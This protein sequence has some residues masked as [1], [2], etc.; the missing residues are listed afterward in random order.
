MTEYYLDVEDVVSDF[1][2]VF[3]V[4]PKARSE[5]TDSNNLTAVNTQFEY[6]VTPS[7]GSV[8]CITS[9]TVN[10]TEQVKWQDYYWDYQNSKVFFLDED[11]FSGGEAIVIN[12]KYG[13]SNWIYSDKPDDELGKAAFPRISLFTIS[14][15]G[16]KIGGAD[17][18]I[19]SRPI[20]QIDCWTRVDEIS[21]IDSRK[22]SNEYLGRYLGNQVVNSFDDSEEKLFGVFFDFDLVGFPRTAPFSEEYNSYHTVVEVRVK[23]LGLGRVKS[24]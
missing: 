17:A 5:T 8:S 6:D 10:G 1:L 19:D 22:Y 23:G 14:G 11:R 7:S 9:L 2:R 3:M 4:D 21:T 15:S 12:F 13:S 20:I 24:V 16:N 18:A